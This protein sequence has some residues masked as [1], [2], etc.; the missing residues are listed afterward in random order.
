MGNTILKDFTLVPPEPYTT[1]K[2]TVLI[3][4]DDY[5]C[6]Y[7]SSFSP[8]IEDVHAFTE[9]YN[10]MQWVHYIGFYMYLVLFL[11]LT[12]KTA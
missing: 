8:H 6:G 2:V 5:N 7:D 9:F 12:V 11:V 1:A 10:V 3:V 4:S